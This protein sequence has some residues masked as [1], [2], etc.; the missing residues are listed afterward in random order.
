M[1][2]M[3]ETD[4]PMKIAELG[5]SIFMAESTK[6]PFT[7]LI[8]TGPQ[9]NQMLSE[10]PAQSFD[11]RGFTGSIDGTDKASWDSTTRLKME[12]YAMW[13]MSNGWM[14]SKLA[15]LT[16]AAGV[17]RKE[18]AKQM[19]DD[20]LHFALQMEKQM[21]SSVDTAAETA[22]T[23]A[24]RSR[25]A[26]SWL[27]NSAQTTK[28]VPE[29]LRPPSACNYASTL[30]LF[31]PAAFIAILEAAAGQIKQPVDLTGFVGILLKGK[32]SSWAQHDPNISDHTAV[33]RFNLDAKDKEFLS[34]VD[35]FSFDAGRVKTVATWNLYCTE[36]TGAASDE[37]TRSGLF[38]DLKMWQK[39]FLQAPMSWKEPPKSGG[40]RG[41]HD[42]VYILK[43]LNPQGQARAIISS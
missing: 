16:K 17:S 20:A 35:F 23:T 25:G 27:S 40:P 34:I 29:D 14:V 24:Y 12:G 9:P 26:F 36:A 38:V 32:M 39:C 31:T 30:A 13:L 42:A 21:L 3:Y 18:Q 10:W 7:R 1:A 22:P 8:K 19:T 41:Y 6:T 2:G 28:P 11:D 43:C 4:Q 5:D 37:T 15:N 33:Q